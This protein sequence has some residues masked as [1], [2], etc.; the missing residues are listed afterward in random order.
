[1]AK[2]SDFDPGLLKLFDGHVH[3]KISRRQF[4]DRAATFAVSG[5]A[6]LAW[7]RTVA[8]FERHLMAGAD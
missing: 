3:G 7:Q 8:H 1:M 2:A 5:A 4:I 6:S